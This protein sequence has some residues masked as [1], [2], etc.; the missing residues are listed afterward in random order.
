MDN[1]ES[2]GLFRPHELKEKW[3]VLVLP[4]PG[5]L[6]DKAEVRIFSHN[7]ALFHTGSVTVL[8]QNR[9]HSWHP[10]GRTQLWQWHSWDCIR[11]GLRLAH[12]PGDPVTWGLYMRAFMRSEDYGPQ[13]ATAYQA[14]SAIANVRK[15][16]AHLK[17]GIE[18]HSSAP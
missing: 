6:V 14:V 3:D 5:H 12:G 9:D 16:L 4:S 10:G 18:G 11:L 2:V 8:G 15:G 13:W 1:L 17:R 7:Y